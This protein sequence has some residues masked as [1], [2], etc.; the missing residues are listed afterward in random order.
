MCGEIGLRLMVS[1]L[2]HAHWATTFAPCREVA[3]VAVEV[4]LL[5]GNQAATSMAKRVR[6]RFTRMSDA[7]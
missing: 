1:W 7:L 2:V 5:Y 3:T 4:K 6:V